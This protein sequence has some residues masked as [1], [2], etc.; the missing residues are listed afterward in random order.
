MIQDSV[1]GWIEVVDYVWVR[2]SDVTTVYVSR[3]SDLEGYPF[4][5]IGVLRQPV[6]VPCYDS[7]KPD[8]ISEVTLDLCETIQ[9]ANNLIIDFMRGKW[10]ST[11]SNQ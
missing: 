1:N 3:D 4:A 11:T 9:E 2:L 10:D 5:V 6:T 7:R 8:E